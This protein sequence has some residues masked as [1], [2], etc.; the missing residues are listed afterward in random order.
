MAERVRVPTLRNLFRKEGLNIPS[1]E[2]R[3]VLYSTYKLGK[4]EDYRGLLEQN[5]SLGEAIQKDT[6]PFDVYVAEIKGKEKLVTKPI[7]SV[8]SVEIA[9]I[10]VPLIP[11]KVELP[12]ST[13]LISPTLSAEVMRKLSPGIRIFPGKRIPIDKIPKIVPAK[14]LARVPKIV[15][16]VR[17][18]PP[19]VKLPIKPLVKLPPVSIV[20]SIPVKRPL[21][22][23]KIYNI[24][25]KR[26]GTLNI[27]EIYQAFRLGRR[28][29]F[30]ATDIQKEGIA[31]E[32]MA[33]PKKAEDLGKELELVKEIQI[34]KEPKK[35]KDLTMK[36]KEPTTPLAKAYVDIEAA[37]SNKGRVEAM[38]KYESK[39]KAIAISNLLRPSFD[40]KKDSK[41]E[42][43]DISYLSDLRRRLKDFSLKKFFVSTPYSTTYDL[44][45][46][47]EIIS[48]ADDLLPLSL[49]QRV[50]RA[51]NIDART[52]ASA[53]PAGIQVSSSGVTTPAIDPSMAVKMV[54]KERLLNIQ[55]RVPKMS[56][57]SDVADPDATIDRLTDE[58]RKELEELVE[59]GLLSKAQKERV[60]LLDE[61]NSKTQALQTLAAGYQEE[62]IGLKF[63]FDKDTG[64]FNVIYE[65]KSIS[66]KEDYRTIIDLVQRAKVLQESLNKD[67]PEVLKLYF[68]TQTQI[69]DLREKLMGN[70]V[71]IADIVYSGLSNVEYNRDPR[72]IA[73]FKSLFPS[74][75]DFTLGGLLPPAD[76]PAYGAELKKL[77]AEY[78]ELIKDPEVSK[79]FD[80]FEK[81]GENEDPFFWETYFRKISPEVF[82]QVERVNILG[83]IITNKS[84]AAMG[85]SF[86]HVMANPIAREAILRI[87]KDRK[88]DESIAKSLLEIMRLEAELEKIAPEVEKAEGKYGKE[89]KRN[90]DLLQNYYSRI[91]WFFDL[92]GAPV[93]PEKPGDPKVVSAKSHTVYNQL[94]EIQDLFRK[95]EKAVKKEDL[96]KYQEESKFWDQYEKSRSY[97]EVFLAPLKTA[98]A[99]L[100]ERTPWLQYEKRE[101]EGIPVYKPVFKWGIEEKKTGFFDIFNNVFSGGFSNYVNYQAFKI[102]WQSAVKALK[103]TTLWY[104]APTPILG[105]PMVAQ[106]FMWQWV[107]KWWPEKILPTLME[108]TLTDLGTAAYILAPEMAKIIFNTKAI[109][110]WD[111]QIAGIEDYKHLTIRE[112]NIPYALG[113]MLG[114]EY[115]RDAEKLL[116][117]P[118]RERIKEEN[119]K[120]WYALSEEAYKEIYKRAEDPFVFKKELPPFR[121]KIEEFL[122][123]N[124]KH[125][126]DDF[127]FLNNRKMGE[128]VELSDP[129]MIPKPTGFAQASNIIIDP[130]T[131]AKLV[132]KNPYASVAMKIWDWNIDILLDPTTYCFS[133]FVDGAIN[134]TKSLMGMQVSIDPLT[135]IVLKGMGKLFNS[136]SILAEYT[137]NFFAGRPIYYS[138]IAQRLPS[139]TRWRETWKPF[140]IIRRLPSDAQDAFFS[141]AKEGKSYEDSLG[142]ALFLKEF[143]TVVQEVPSAK[144]M[145]RFKELMPTFQDLI[146]D[147]RFDPL[148]K[149]SDPIYRLLNKL[150]ADGF[151]MLIK[152]ANE[153]DYR[154]L[155]KELIKALKNGIKPSTLQ[156]I[157]FE[158]L[159][160]KD[161]L[162][163]TEAEKNVIRA[164]LKQKTAAGRTK[165]ITQ[166]KRIA[167]DGGFKMKKTRLNLN[168][169]LDT[170]LFTWQRPEFTAGAVEKVLKAEKKIRAAI[171]ETETTIKRS[172]FFKKMP[173][174]FE[175]RIN[176]ALK[177]PVLN[178]PVHKVLMLNPHKTVYGEN[179]ITYNFTEDIAN[180]FIDFFEGPKSKI[181]RIS[182]SYYRSSLKLPPIFSS[183]KYIKTFQKSFDVGMK[184]V[185][186]YSSYDVIAR[187]PKLRLKKLP[188]LESVS[189]MLQGKSISKKDFQEAFR[190]FH[191]NKTDFIWKGRK[192][193]DAFK[194]PVYKKYLD[195]ISLHPY[196]D[197][198]I[199]FLYG[200]RLKSLNFKI[201]NSDTLISLSKK[202]AKYRY[203]TE[204]FKKIMTDFKKVALVGEVKSQNLFDY[205]DDLSRRAID[206]LSS[207]EYA[208]IPS[209]IKKVMKGD[210]LT[211]EEAIGILSD[212]SKLY[213]NPIDKAKNS[214]TDNLF[215]RRYFKTI[216]SVLDPFYISK[217]DN[218][219]LLYVDRLFRDIRK[220]LWV[221]LEAILKHAK[222]Y[223]FLDQELHDKAISKLWKPSFYQYALYDSVGNYLAPIEKIDPG[224]KKFVGTSFGK[225]A[226]NN[227]NSSKAKMEQWVPVTEHEFFNGIESL[228]R[229]FYD[230]TKGAKWLTKGEFE[231]I[232]AMYRNVKKYIPSKKT[233]V[234]RKGVDGLLWWKQNPVEQ[235][236]YKMFDMPGI[237]TIE[238]ALKITSD[239]ISITYPENFKAYLRDAISLYYLQKYAPK[240]A[241]DL[242]SYLKRMI[243]Y[244]PELFTDEQKVFYEM[245]KQTGGKHLFPKA[246]EDLLEGI[247]VRNYSTANKPFE[248][249]YDKLISVVKKDWYWDHVGDIKKGFKNLGFPLEDFD[250]VFKLTFV[251]FHESA[252]HGSVLS[253]FL[254]PFSAMERV[255]RKIPKK[256]FFKTAPGYFPK[257]ALTREEAF[258]TFTPEME[259]WSNI[260]SR[261]LPQE[262]PEGVFKIITD[263]STVQR[264]ASKKS[265]V[266]PWVAEE[267]RQRSAV[268]NKIYRSKIL[269]AVLKEPDRIYI[270][271][272]KDFDPKLY[273]DIVSRIGKER[274]RILPE[275]GQV[276]K[277]G[278]L[279]ESEALA[280]VKEFDG[281]LNLL[282]PGGRTIK[283]NNLLTFWSNM[284]EMRTI[285]GWE[286][287]G[288]HKN[289]KWGTFVDLDQAQKLRE[290]LIENLEK[291]KTSVAKAWLDGISK[292]TL[293]NTYDRPKLIEALWGIDGF[294]KYFTGIFMA[295]KIKVEIIH[296]KRY[297]RPLVKSPI[298]KKGNLEFGL[299]PA[300]DPDAWIV[301]RGYEIL[302]DTPSSIKL[303]LKR[304]E[305][306]IDLRLSEFLK[307]NPDDFT[308]HE[309]GAWMN[310]LLD[311]NQFAESKEFVSFIDN[312]LRAELS[313]DKIIKKL[314]YRLRALKGNKTKLFDRLHNLS[315]SA[316][317]VETKFKLKKGSTKWVKELADATKRTQKIDKKIK[318]TIIRQEY[319]RNSTFNKNLKPL[320]EAREKLGLRSPIYSHYEAK[321]L[322]YLI[323]KD[324]GFD[325]FITEAQTALKRLD[326]DRE[327][328]Q[329]ALNGFTQ[330]KAAGEK[331]V[332]LEL[333][334][335]IMTRKV[336]VSDIVLDKVDP[337]YRALVNSQFHKEGLTKPLSID[338]YA[339]TFHYIFGQE[340]LTE[341][342]RAKK[343]V[344]S[345]TMLSKELLK[346]RGI[347]PIDFAIEKT[348]ELLLAEEKIISN[349]HTLEKLIPVFS[350]VKSLGPKGWNQFLTDIWN[351]QNGMPTIKTVKSIQERRLRLLNHM[352]GKKLAMNVLDI[353][354]LLAKNSDFVSIID[355]SKYSFSDKVVSRWMAVWGAAKAKLPITSSIIE[356]EKVIKFIEGNKVDYAIFTYPV[357]AKIRKLMSV[358]GGAYVVIDATI[359]LL[360][361]NSKWVSPKELKLMKQYRGHIFANKRVAIIGGDAEMVNKRLLKIL[362]PKEKFAIDQV[363]FARKFPEPVLPKYT[364]DPW[365]MPRAN[366]LRTKY[367]QEEVERIK[368]ILPDDQSRKILEYTKHPAKDLKF[369]EIPSW[370]HKRLLTTQF[371][372]LDRFF[373]SS[374]EF[375]EIWAKK[376]KGEAF[377]G[378]NPKWPKMVEVN[379]PGKLTA[380]MVDEIK[381]WKGFG[382][383][384]YS[385]KKVLTVSEKN[386]ADLAGITIKKIKKPLVHFKIFNP[387][388]VSPVSLPSISKLRSKFEGEIVSVLR[389]ANVD[390]K[391]LYPH[392]FLSKEQLIKNPVSFVRSFYLKQ[393]KADLTSR[394]EKWQAS[395]IEGY[396]ERF[397]H[398]YMKAKGVWDDGGK[399]LLKKQLVDAEA[400]IEI[401]KGTF[402]G[403]SSNDPRFKLP[404][405]LESI[406]MKAREGI[407]K[408]LDLKMIDHSMKRYN[409]WG[410]A[411]DLSTFY[412]SSMKA[413]NGT[414]N[415]LGL[416]PIK[417]FKTFRNVWIWSVL[418]L[419]PAWYLRN[420][421]DDA[422]RGAVGARS[423][424]AYIDSWRLFGLSSLHGVS[425]IGMS[426]M[427]LGLGVIKK[428]VSAL[429]Y[430]LRRL[431][432]E[433][434]GKILKQNRKIFNFVPIE[435]KNK[436]VK[437]LKQFWQWDPAEAFQRRML[438]SLAKRKA[439]TAVEL[440][441]KFGKKAATN[442]FKNN[443]FSRNDKLITI[444]FIKNLRNRGAILN[445]DANDL[446]SRFKHIPTDTILNP[447]QFRVVNDTLQF[448]EYDRTINP[449][450]L[451]NLMKGRKPLATFDPELI[452]KFYRTGQLSMFEKTLGARKWAKYYNSDFWIK[453]YGMSSSEVKRAI[454]G[455]FFGV[456][457]DPVAMAKLVEGLRSMGYNNLISQRFALWRADIILWANAQEEIRRMIVLDNMLHRFAKNK[458]AAIET[459]RKWMF[460]YSDISR[461]TKALRTFFPFISFTQKNAELIGS[462]FA[463]RGPVAYKTFLLL[464]QTWNE[465][466]KD[467][468][469]WYKYRVKIPGTKYWYR[470]PFSFL[471]FLPF[472]TKPYETVLEFF[473]NPQRFPLG[474]SIGPFSS[475]ILKAISK[476]D[477]WDVS[478]Y[479]QQHMGWT[480]EEADAEARRAN[481]EK[482]NFVDDTFSTLTTLFPLAQI[483]PAL[484]PQ[485]QKI[486]ESFLRDEINLMDS[487]TFRDFFK[488]IGFNVYREKDWEKVV[489]MIGDTPPHLKSIFMKHLK[490]TDPEAYKSFQNYWVRVAQVRVFNSPDPE[491]IPH[492]RAL[493]IHDLRK[494]IA[495]EMYYDLEDRHKG[496]G[497]RW[498]EKTKK[499]GNMEPTILMKESWIDWNNIGTYRALQAKRLEE[500]KI[501]ILND[502]ISGLPT[503]WTLEDSQK[504]A[505]IEDELESPVPSAF[506]KEDFRNLVF[507]T[508]GRLKVKN[509]DTAIAIVEKKFKEDG[510]IGLMS[511][512]VKKKREVDKL[513]YRL[514]SWAD[515]QLKKEKDRIYHSKLATVWDAIPEDYEELSDELSS[516]ERAKIWEEVE[517]RMANMLTA[518][519][520]LRYEN[521]NPEYVKKKHELTK[522]YLDIWNQLSKKMETEN[523]NEWHWLIDGV[524][525]QPEWFREFNFIDHP[526]HRKTWPGQLK[527]AIKK[528]EDRLSRLKGYSS[529]SAE[530]FLW[531][532]D[533][534][535]KALRTA[536][537]LKDEITYQKA[538]RKLSQRVDTA[539][540]HDQDILYYTWWF[541]MPQK[542]Q[543]YYWEKV[544]K[545]GKAELSMT[546]NWYKFSLLREKGRKIDRS[547]QE[548]GIESY[549]E[550]KVFDDSIWTKLFKWKEKDPTWLGF[551]DYYKKYFA[552]QKADTKKPFYKWLYEDLNDKERTFYFRHHLGVIGYSSFMYKYQVFQDKDLDAAEKYF[553]S[554]SNGKYRKALEKNNPGEISYRKELK[555]ILDQVRKTGK[556]FY[557]FL[558]TVSKE[559]KEKYLKRH[560]FATTYLSA[561]IK[562][563]ELQEKDSVLARK[564]FKTDGYQKAL[565]A[566]DNEKPGT[567]EYQWGWYKIIEKAEKFG[568]DKFTEILLEYCKKKPIFKKYLETN[569]PG[570]L[571]IL[572]PFR[573]RFFASPSHSAWSFFWL[574]VNKK[575]RDMW[576]KE[577]PGIIKY[578]GFWKELTQLASDRKWGEYFAFYNANG[579]RIYR[580]R[581]WEVNPKNEKTWIAWEKYQALP[582]YTWEEKRARK[583]FLEENKLLQEKFQAGLEPDEKKLFELIDKY[584]VI[585]N[586]VP[587]DGNDAKYFEAYARAK[588]LG[589]KF[590]EDHP[591]VAAY[592]FDKSKK[593]I[594]P[595]KDV[596]EMRDFYFSIEYEL[597]RRRY[598][599]KHPKLQ[600]YFL[601]TQSP[602]IRKV[603]KLQAQYFDLKS[604][605]AK[606]KFLETNPSL[607][608]YWE[609]KELPVSY[610]LEPNKFKPFKETSIRASEYFRIWR[611]K[612]WSSAEK[613]RQVLSSLFFSPGTSPEGLWLRKKIYLDAMQTWIKVS[614][615]SSFQGVLF[616]RQLPDWV[617]DKYYLRHPAMKYL[618]KYRLSRFILEPFIR[619]D[620]K[621]L[622]YF[623]AIRKHYEYNGYTNL[624]SELKD[625][626]RRQM[627]AKGVWKTRAHWTK[628]EWELYYRKS[629]LKLNHLKSVDLARHPLLRKE[630]ELA[631]RTYLHKG[632]PKPWK[633]RTLPSPLPYTL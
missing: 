167:K 292:L 345:K 102:D 155:G 504:V 5:L 470:M 620:A 224:I 266:I 346:G 73:S 250:K 465:T 177:T 429:G 157:A 592:F 340:E 392:T 204:E 416:F 604:Y 211:K 94:I 231:N 410:R 633:K 454:S 294:R 341:V 253:E 376:M 479:L 594:G 229:Y 458:I 119:L 603:M 33:M 290:Y 359:D 267:A 503:E 551:E 461:G 249:F 413:V 152:T 547:Q 455:G 366:I 16:A 196:V 81:H 608:I 401:G 391:K 168:G 505:L 291:Q 506:K 202:L 122:P 206:Q 162:G 385:S 311:I 414:I 299:S 154:V 613:K 629:A 573:T 166:L 44:K 468:P 630:F 25:A 39:E 316:S 176:R 141:Y 264:N 591:D 312:F 406:L 217:L 130:I 276:P 520:R 132:Q 324:V 248:E 529:N 226:L 243:P 378:W 42:K 191:D 417:A 377:K 296:G 75:E 495:R 59:E 368:F 510:I 318:D 615:R 519:E 450:F 43:F 540:D 238:K 153:G 219:H 218:I 190:F 170:K 2:R 174:D 223:G 549:Q 77:D 499:D 181:A 419:R 383:R 358:K 400:A 307:W 89:M 476:K 48:R 171:L 522:E 533:S 315:S 570:Y 283:D 611:T 525:K 183:S 54:E 328:I 71:E 137:Y 335:K 209:T 199:E 481:V 99:W 617:R 297:F 339:D 478:R 98:T 216:L 178:D 326:T 430:V 288:K 493:A 277:V 427:S 293:E 375:N 268:E 511:E 147:G 34:E 448:L 532:N 537:S 388:K 200:A 600:E 555:V 545:I 207:D 24:Y 1:I 546:K 7:E 327:Y 456:E 562:Y 111:T 574:S 320:I 101:W 128:I 131:R 134:A 516:E 225:E 619:V 18:K 580:D 527:W 63:E 426:T 58:S 110:A 354:S 399:K 372:D 68:K 583:N 347:R 251:R 78:A 310:S 220:E 146:I 397:K 624:P 542:I 627:I 180:K 201:R 585:K 304:Q 586:Q 165:I 247:S 462:I 373:T 438:K 135:P 19:V 395:W 452:G 618:S 370:Y 35:I 405:S 590:L 621:R 363:V 169:I 360:P 140:S 27:P 197:E 272:K 439:S 443:I 242:L 79:V 588:V 329:K 536:S 381:I 40:V 336:L 279:K 57:L 289:I 384:F 45:K 524:Y 490:K 575:A 568:Q 91:N 158:E 303:I 625:E 192:L 15:P 501:G 610:F 408:K 321:L 256:W 252:I 473:D 85:Q 334:P 474:L 300:Q 589:D 531:S 235:R 62:K 564:F 325:R 402:L 56:S 88:T 193:S 483:L 305:E 13:K 596:I 579:N 116:S 195:K 352:K 175:F 587:E 348:R 36:I 8:K 338:Y 344:Y 93:D 361:F 12:K 84:T 126:I 389:K 411:E 606:N 332:I 317:F 447:R 365:R 581:H 287:K 544:A 314:D 38:T 556:S 496:D 571:D 26:V 96:A 69:Q 260:M 486:D 70:I 112:R 172:S 552:R 143:S 431:M 286:T 240:E 52:I 66:K 553:W 269:D 188:K 560:P 337:S 628:I 118:F 357:P 113:T 422:L 258:A 477:L 115:G 205:V 444:S 313:I 60:E 28:E 434:W 301:S 421:I 409:R 87:L 517:F 460:D 104:W 428:S 31:R 333:E 173:V 29:D 124:Y 515:K 565:K 233:K 631:Y 423:F 51:R 403:I 342:I 367:T 548:K 538:M 160:Y 46:T 561:F 259:T 541:Q 159:L 92:F 213:F 331:Y 497:V 212:I 151:A 407:S 512:E 464:N 194:L 442:L 472:I 198:G 281:S 265:R 76:T 582:E 280:L 356:P 273:S 150:D 11:K 270:F 275:M 236:Y 514:T 142:N 208:L 605:E 528:R 74:R 145:A 90:V 612:N 492:V 393:K 261:R 566:K 319:V 362:P 498:L 161:L 95:Y 597:L 72:L 164:L 543:N 262:T 10:K 120:K 449:T 390:F 424:R 121:G 278:I 106:E 330:K 65:D 53:I 471:D 467:L 23:P 6:T 457:E 394:F 418:Y 244:N 500:D 396:K 17:E 67:A 459:T 103:K 117:L 559:F 578:L 507:D 601:A 179:G 535:A 616:F 441:R 241:T 215:S 484:I 22:V 485:L 446:L 100:K 518:E 374:S 64:R 557:L 49:P 136:G 108:T 255:S 380:D 55:R 482:V 343:L 37:V 323:D 487:K 584:N 309:V 271:S 494:A 567:Y 415:T 489:K 149:N 30:K 595:H 274:V 351:I 436:G 230:S 609:Y 379:I 349:I 182:T 254:R 353:D 502:M 445:L 148:A 306:L 285:V 369:N 513:N 210:S 263:A 599:M 598:I 350:D 626:V 9:K 47:S 156:T 463:R 488:F 475:L 109:Q 523:S 539:I 133:D 364:A 607:V 239:T 425:Y 622:G 221:N 322:G 97:Y 125:L 21:V 237:R 387:Y 257:R 214:L 614:K 530:K 602:G 14:L 572:I 4:P 404:E 632:I 82:R 435:V 295:D 480:K 227:I 491:K 222:R 105:T 420:H 563:A 3:R 86:S 83:Q 550:A 623:S 466:V 302:G 576:E 398:G 440:A 453:E 50:E 298:F 437:V 234:I 355:T 534:L 163:L 127:L 61:I 593:Y 451:K 114:A 526:E 107:S 371:E 284:P 469:D 386:L 139:I 184:E 433:G 203:G 245:W 432:P 569:R 144:R 508:W 41:K 509:P 187:F 138:P 20:P 282:N 228:Y 577:D 232:L 123:E 246:F 186:D 308:L 189:N 554:K 80:D 129:I 382:C 185:I 558:K 412:L 32:L 521:D